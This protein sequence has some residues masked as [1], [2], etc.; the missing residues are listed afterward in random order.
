MPRRS[1]DHTTNDSTSY[2]LQSFGRRK[3]EIP[4]KEPPPKTSLQDLLRSVGSRGSKVM[5]TA[6]PDSQRR[7][8]SGRSKSPRSSPGGSWKPQREARV[9]IRSSARME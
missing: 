4:P 3:E 7:A 6:P 2:G 1:G 9:L 8:S 5:V